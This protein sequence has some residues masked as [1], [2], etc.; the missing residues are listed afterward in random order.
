[1]TDEIINLAVRLRQGR[2]M[3]LSDSLI[4]ATALAFELDLATRN[5][6]D[7]AQIPGLTVY[8]PFAA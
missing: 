3:S 1:M 6:S 2:R 7:F 8:D 5:V 4:G